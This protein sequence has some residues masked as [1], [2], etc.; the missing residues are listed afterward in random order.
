MLKRRWCKISWSDITFTFPFTI[1]TLIIA[2]VA[3]IA[4]S[5]LITNRLK[6]TIQ[7]IIWISLVLIFDL[8]FPRGYGFRFLLAI[9]MML[10]SRMRLPETG[11]LKEVQMIVITLVTAML[12][13][14]LR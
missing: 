6:R 11:L 3:Y 7:F 2:V 1:P 4:S 13:V 12:F 10:A 14:G 5:T 8:I 9:A